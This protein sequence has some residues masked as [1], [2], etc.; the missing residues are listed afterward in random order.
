MTDARPRFSIFASF[1]AA[2][3]VAGLVAAPLLAAARLSSHQPVPVTAWATAGAVSI[4][5]L[6]LFA[7]ANARCSSERLT[8]REGLLFVTSSMMTGWTYL[9]LL[10]VFPALLFTFIASVG[11]AIVNDIAGTR[12][13]SAQTFHRLVAGFHR[14]R[15]RQ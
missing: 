11:I 7:Y 2:L 6:A 4:L 1:Y 13:R 5:V 14:H 10:F 3:F 12:Q 15:M 8:Y 9:S